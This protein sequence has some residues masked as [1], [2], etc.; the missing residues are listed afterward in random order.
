MVGVP[1]AQETVGCGDWTTAIGEI[2]AASHRHTGP[3]VCHLAV[4][5]RQRCRVSYKDSVRYDDEVSDK[6]LWVT[7]PLEGVKGSYWGPAP[8]PQAPYCW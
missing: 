6:V 5:R 8:P 4:G 7:V 1:Y 2:K 3:R